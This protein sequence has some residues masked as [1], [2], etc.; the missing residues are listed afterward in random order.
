MEGKNP[1]LL[2]VF[3][4]DYAYERKKNGIYRSPHR[5]LKLKKIKVI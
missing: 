5:Q 1:K 2:E 3:T 4:D